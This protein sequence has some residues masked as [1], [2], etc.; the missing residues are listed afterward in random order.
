MFVTVQLIKTQVDLV[1]T[2]LYDIFMS[3][4]CVHVFIVWHE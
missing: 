2:I 1:K 3:L 4:I